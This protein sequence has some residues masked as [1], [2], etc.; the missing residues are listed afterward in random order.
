MELMEEQGGI[1]IM[2]DSAFVLAYPKNK[3]AEK[4]MTVILLIFDIP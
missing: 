3:W 4:N 1:N 2:G